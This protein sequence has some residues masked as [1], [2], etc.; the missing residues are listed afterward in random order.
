MDMTMTDEG[1]ISAAA[2]DEPMIMPNG[3]SV[4]S[5][6]PLIDI[7][8]NDNPDSGYIFLDNR[9]SGSNSY[10]VIF[11]NTGS[12]IWYLQT[13][14]ERRD[15]KVQH[16]G[17]LTMLARTGGYRFVGLDTNYREVASYRAVNGYSTD[18]HELQ[19]LEDGR[20]LLIGLRHEYVDMTQ[21]LPGA[22]SNARVGQTIIQEFTPEGGQFS[23]PPYE[24]YWY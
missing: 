4:P 2:L 17:V 23:L 21:Y 6:F 11:D 19:M 15:M 5:N 20:Y 18:E 7:T 13:S 14:D 9:T 10:N 16:N 3:V 12:P 22:N 1:G 24:C 8:I